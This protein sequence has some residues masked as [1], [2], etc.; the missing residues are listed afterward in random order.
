M[1]LRDNAHIGKSEGF[2]V[3]QSSAALDSLSAGEMLTHK[4]PLKCGLSA[5]RF[6]T[7]ACDRQGDGVRRRVRRDG[8]RVVRAAVGAQYRISDTLRRSHESA[9]LGGDSRRAGR[10][11]QGIRDD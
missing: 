7:V 3:R 4:L 5:V 10:G 9:V 11:L 6:A 1:T 8:N 2:G